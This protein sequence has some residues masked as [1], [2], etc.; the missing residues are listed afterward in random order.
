MKF[1]VISIYP[2]S[3]SLCADQSRTSWES[4]PMGVEYLF[5]G[6]ICLKLGKFTEGNHD[7][8][9]ARIGVLNRAPQLKERSGRYRHPD[10][11]PI[12]E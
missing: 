10:A 3:T 9:Y 7:S 2:I 4:A 1:S 6:L 8:K 12:E 5:M 11:V